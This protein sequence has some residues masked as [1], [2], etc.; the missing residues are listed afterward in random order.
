MQFVDGSHYLQDLGYLVAVTGRGH[1]SQLYPRPRAGFSGL[2]GLSAVA[3]AGAV[4]TRAIWHVS[5]RPS[6]PQTTAVLDNLN[7]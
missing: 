1:A 6:D 4:P 2:T 7:T 3:P 5:G